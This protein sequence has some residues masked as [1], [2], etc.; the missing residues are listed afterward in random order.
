MAG[1]YKGLTIKFGA[2]TTGLDSAMSQIDSKGK[3]LSRNMKQVNKA[4]KVDPKNTELLRQK[5]ETL[6]KQVANTEEKLKALKD[7]EANIGKGGMSSDQ[8][9]QLQRDIATTEASLKDYREQFKQANVE[10][11]VADS[12]LGQFGQ[13]IVDIGNK[14]EPMGETL[15]SVGGK[16]SAAITAPA[17]AAGVASVSIAQ[18]FE[19]SLAKVSTLADENVM[20]MDEIGD[21]ARELARQYGVSASGINEALYQALSASVDTA[22]A[23]EFVGEATKLSKAG[24]TES[25]TAVDVLTTAINAYGLSADDAAH[26][27]DVLVNTQNLGKT[28]VNEL[29]SSMGNVI[30]TA[31]AYGVNLENLSSAYAVMTKQG[32]N[33]ANATTAINGM[34]TELADG[35]SDV[36]GILQEMSG[37]TFAQL[38]N[39][40]ASLGDV[41]SMLNEHV[42][43][44]SE[45]FA[46]LWGNMRASKGAL[47]IANAGADEFNKTLDSMV[48]AS[49]VVDEA[50]EKLGGTTQSAMNKMKAEVEDAAIAVGQVLLPFVQEGAALVKGA[51]A[52]FNELSDA[53]KENVVHLVALAAGMGPVLSLLGTLMTSVKGVGAGVIS[54][55][56]ML[57]KLD[58][59]TNG[60]ARGIT[61][62]TNAAGETVTKLNRAS[63][64]MGGLKMA[65]ALA[66]V[67]GVALLVKQLVDMQQNWANL[68]KATNGMTAAMASVKSSSEV[69]SI[70]LKSQS[71][72]AEGATRSID[73]YV[74]AAR[75]AAEEGAKFADKISGTFSGAET[76]AAMVQMY[77]DKILELSGN[78]GGSAEKIAEL[79]LAVEKYNELTGSSLSVVDDYSGR[80]NAQTDEILA[81]TA[82]AKENAYAKAAAGLLEESARREIEL[83]SELTQ[84]QEALSEARQKAAEAEVQL[85]GATDITSDEYAEAY[86]SAAQYS[87]EVAK[88]EESTSSLEKQ[89]ATQQQTT[90]GLEESYTS[91]A[92]AAA[93]ASEEAKNAAATAKDYQSALGD[94]EAFA[95]IA[96]ACNYSQEQLN[97]FASALSDAGINAERLASVGAEE[98]SRL[99][100]EAQGDLSAVNDALNFLDYFEIQP[101][102]VSITEDGSAEVMGH[103]VDLNNMTIDGKEFE[104]EDDGSITVEGE[105]V[106]GLQADVDKLGSTTAKPK[107]EAS[108]NV[109]ST[110]SSAESAM[111]RIDGKRADTYIYEHHVTTNEKGSGQ[112]SG[113]VNSTIIRALPA[114]ASGAALSGIVTR[115]TLTNQGL[116]GEA[117]AEAVIRNGRSSAVV[118]LTNRRYVRPF[119]QAVAAEIGAASGQIVNNYYSLNGL[120]VQAGSREANALEVLADA[121]SRERRS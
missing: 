62:M 107:I 110:V 46:N 79:K 101:K 26:V 113:G 54:F 50:L 80:V 14:I 77:S 102:D 96:Q 93:K 36:N 111:N 71:D 48:N 82:A 100:N 75:E 44:D 115:P 61:T 69:A 118:P 3:S 56:T 84:Q 95:Q 108:S 30:P 18:D 8:W 90:A 53:E 31:A 119:A 87:G 38:M 17:V 51:A 103:I 116:I 57:A 68:D 13:S 105:K 76:D 78:C 58:M 47:A 43:G 5:F 12:K 1:I 7:A 35:G 106:Q 114:F 19:T 117:G 59:A 55:A 29:A 33:T 60:A 70:G 49:G 67:A 24:F 4:L 27:S 10:Y 72:A 9:D 37:K 52:A 94:S 28:T 83:Q 91:Y 6:G 11:A 86:A 104:I 20:T 22:H 88:L 23:L 99:S 89:L 2:D 15:K 65:A 42:D 81:N 74:Q 21:G 66:A 32:I 34:L 40:G 45:A 39:D 16:M 41:I 109:E 63:V 112:A 120:T 64:A 73:S 97:E 98:F 121:M 25:A 92:A 85:Q